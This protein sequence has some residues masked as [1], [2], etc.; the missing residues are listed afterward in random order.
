M[1]H[2]KRLT[3]KTN[4]SGKDFRVF[5]RRDLEEVVKSADP[6]KVLEVCIN[7]MI[8]SWEKECG[9]PLQAAKMILQLYKTD[10]PWFSAARTA[11][12]VR[13]SFVLVD[14]AAKQA[15]AY[16]EQVMNW[17][18][19]LRPILRQKKPLDPLSCVRSKVWTVADEATVA[20]LV[21]RAVFDESARAELS[22]QA[23]SVVGGRSPTRAKNLIE[24]IEAA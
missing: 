6:I 18:E 17:T 12:M 3:D 2:E 7:Q 4:L 16:A 24:A 10:H 21:I 11:E 22:M 20:A 1:T 14:A 15:T 9:S 8:P 13:Q 19:A 23:A 5:V